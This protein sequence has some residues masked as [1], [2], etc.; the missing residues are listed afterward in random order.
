M[1]L[2]NDTLKEEPIF[3]VKTGDSRNPTVKSRKLVYIWS[4][5]TSDKENDHK[6]Q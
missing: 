6:N 2:I 4:S 3:I 1:I 5:T